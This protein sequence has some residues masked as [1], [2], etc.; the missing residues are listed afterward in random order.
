M[1]EKQSEVKNVKNY[2][3]RR[4]RKRFT[5][6]TKERELG[7]RRSGGQPPV[8]AEREKLTSGICENGGAHRQ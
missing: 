4:N 7:G 6:H 2:A 1:K 3:W 8:S 5:N